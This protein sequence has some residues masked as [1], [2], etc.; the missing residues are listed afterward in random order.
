MTHSTSSAAVL[1][2]TRTPREEAHSKNFSEG[3]RKQQQLISKKLISATI[4]KARKSGL[5]Y[6][7]NYSD[8][9]RGN[10][11]G[12]RFS[13]AVL[14]I[15]EKGYHH[16]IAIGND[17][18]QLSSET[19]R[20]AVA[21]LKQ[22]ELVLGPDLRGGVYLIG[23]SKKIFSTQSFLDFKWNSNSLFA[24]MMNW[25]EHNFYSCSLLPDLADINSASDL[26]IILSQRKISAALLFE[27]FS[28]L[29]SA[30]V[31]LNYFFFYERTDISD[32]H[33]HRG[34]PVLHHGITSA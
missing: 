33:P 9:Q 3:T 24:E 1:I 13:N 21:L 28:I 7:I 23:V 16:V 18:P 20:A 14:E 10:S 30:K 12:E 19:L 26:K 6:F 17:A 4:R 8:Q 31:L 11:F 25:S 5:P 32:F 22:K 29:A 2:F 34:P 15:F 27:L